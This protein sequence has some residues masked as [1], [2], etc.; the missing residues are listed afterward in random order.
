MRKRMVLKKQFGGSFPQYP[1]GK[2]HPRKMLSSKKIRTTY[3]SCLFLTFPLQTLFS[4]YRASN[5]SYF[6]KPEF[7]F[8][9]NRNK[10]RVFPAKGE[11]KIYAA[12]LRGPR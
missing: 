10:V 8:V 12:K 4:I 2:A 7:F 1:T 9:K 11:T 3:T 5:E 6:Q